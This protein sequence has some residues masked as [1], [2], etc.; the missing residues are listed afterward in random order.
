[1]VFLPFAVMLE[2]FTALTAENLARQYARAFT[3]N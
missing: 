2:H 3:E 1:L